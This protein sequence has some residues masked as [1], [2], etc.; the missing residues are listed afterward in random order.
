[1]FSSLL[2][3][4]IGQNFHLFLKIATIKIYSIFYQPMWLQ[5]LRHIMFMVYFLHHSFKNVT[6]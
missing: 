2:K 5:S 4:F 3:E 1:M 6:F